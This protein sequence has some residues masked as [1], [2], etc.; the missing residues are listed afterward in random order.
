MW[1]P[2]IYS[3]N[4][5]HKE[6]KLATLNED[7]KEFKTKN[8]D[9]DTIEIRYLN[10]LLLLSD[11][12]SQFVGKF[13][14]LMNTPDY[15]ISNT[16][17]EVIRNEY[18]KYL[19]DNNINFNDFIVAIRDVENL[20][21]APKSEKM[22]GL[23]AKID[24]ACVAEQLRIELIQDSILKNKNLIIMKNIDNYFDI[25]FRPVKQFRV[26]ET[27][28]VNKSGKVI[29]DINYKINI[30]DKKNQ[31]IKSIETSAVDIELAEKAVLV[32]KFYEKTDKE[33]FDILNNVKNLGR[34]NTECTGI[35]I[36]DNLD[37]KPSK[38]VSEYCLYLN[39]DHPLLI[40]LDEER[41]NRL[42][43]LEAASPIIARQLI[44]IK[45]I[46]GLGENVNL[47]DK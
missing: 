24:S 4:V 40:K 38:K 43:Q 10:D 21:K 29:K 11:D 36:A 8:L 41:N 6:I 15:V 9:L 34:I 39:Y 13:Y 2:M 30:L 45:K 46:F 35:K 22:N 12:Y 47:Y 1:L 37:Y 27:Q 42:R 31:L 16:E 7:I 14:G 28:I 32:D 26:L 19:E 44:A 17:F 20:K 5:S 33:I 23:Y 3:C 25:T 18:F